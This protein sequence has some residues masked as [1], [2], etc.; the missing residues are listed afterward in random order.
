METM[1]TA[2]NGAHRIAG[3]FYTTC[4]NGRCGNT[5]DENMMS[6]IQVELRQRDD[7]TT[8]DNLKKSE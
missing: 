4:P 3:R 7:T 2:E 5:G 8:W 1:Q 6:R